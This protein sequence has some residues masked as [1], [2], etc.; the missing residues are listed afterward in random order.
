VVDSKARSKS[1]V[2][3]RGPSESSKPPLKSLASRAAL[4]IHDSVH[5]DS[6]TVANFWVEASTVIGEALV[7]GWNQK[8]M[9]ENDV[10]TMASIPAFTRGSL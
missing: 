1:S 3:Q 4:L 6:G 7:S 10:R 9:R 8:V 5:T 2:I